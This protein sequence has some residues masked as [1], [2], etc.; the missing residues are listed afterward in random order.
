[1]AHKVL[2]KSRLP[3]SMRAQLE[4]LLFFN[5]GQHR[6][7]E[8]IAA[9]IERYG[10]PELI[11]DGGWLRIDVAGGRGVQTLYAVHEENGRERPVGV[12]VYAR[13]ALDHI[14]VL[15]VGVARDYAAGGWHAGE[16]VLQRMM[17]HIRDVARRTSGV[18]H[19]AVAYREN[20]LR[21]ATA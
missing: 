9:T 2:V 1:M 3:A 16:R 7:R 14:T 8:A 6:M 19:V 17:Q 10:L 4:A 20:R 5:A 13:D 15:H 11:E 21:S 12:I 18:R